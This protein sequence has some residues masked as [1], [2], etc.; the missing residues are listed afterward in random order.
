MKIVWTKSKLPLSVGIR[1]LLEEDSSHVMFIFDDKFAVQSN[2]IG[3]QLGWAS[4]VLKHCEIV[5]E[6]TFSLPLQDEET[7]YRSIMD[8]FDDEPYDFKAFAYF[9]WRGFLKKFF[10]KPMPTHSP[11]NSKGFLCVEIAKEIEWSTINPR[12]GFINAIALNI[13]SPTKLYKYMV[14]SLS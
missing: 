10:K 5:H 12:L 7:I 9:A 8:N 11:Y 1:W 6:M 4:T 2:L 3:V 13:T 14:K